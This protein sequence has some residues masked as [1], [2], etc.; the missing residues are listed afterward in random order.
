M[1][2]KTQQAEKTEDK[3]DGDS[4]STYAFL[5]FLGALLAFIA[6]I[7]IV[8]RFFNSSTPGAQDSYTY[9]YFDFIEVNDVWYTT[10]QEG[11]NLVRVSLRHGPRELENI[12]VVGNITDFRDR[13]DFMYITFDPRQEN[14]DGYV[15][16]SVTE[17]STNLVAHFGKGIAA[18]C[19][20]P[21]PVCNETNTS[22]ITCQNTDRGV[23]YLYHTNTTSVVISGNCAIISG[24]GENMVRASDRFLYSMY[25]IMK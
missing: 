5:V 7:I 22:I 2:K 24:I 17:L 9:N 19:A 12:S 16:L 4:K 20:F 10:A 3:E 11:P 8:P 21:D 1:A 23:I 13:N 6:I 18:G 25:G 15:T 14:H